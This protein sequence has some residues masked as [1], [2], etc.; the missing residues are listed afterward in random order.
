MTVLMALSITA[1]QQSKATKNTWNAAKQLLD[2]LASNPEATSQYSASDTVLNIYS[3]APYLSEPN[4]RSCACG[5]FFLGWMPVDGE[6]IKL[7]GAFITLS[8]TRC[9]LLQLQRRKDIPPHPQGIG[10]SISC[11]TSALQQQNSSQHSQQHLQKTSLKIHG[12]AIIL[13][14]GPSE[15][16]ILSHPM[17]SRTG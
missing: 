11:H 5:C 6:P 14:G 8:A 12:D 7:N 13:G 1:S 4:A 16:R 15:S 3:D 9:P 2:Y 17:V 10:S